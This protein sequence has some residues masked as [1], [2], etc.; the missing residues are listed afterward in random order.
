VRGWIGDGARALVER[1]VADRADPRG[2]R[3]LRDPRG[4]AVTEP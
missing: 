1:A 2:A 4:P 3:D